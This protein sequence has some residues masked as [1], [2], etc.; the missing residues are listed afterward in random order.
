M[1]FFTKEKLDE[2]LKAEHELVTLRQPVKF[3]IDGDILEYPLYKL[4]E[5]REYRAWFSSQVAINDPSVETVSAIQ[6][7]GSKGL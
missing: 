4:N 3:V 2:I 7:F 6:I 5:L 1:S